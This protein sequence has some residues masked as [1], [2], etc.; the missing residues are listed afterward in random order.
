MNQKMNGIVNWQASDCRY[1]ARV[2]GLSADFVLGTD[3]LLDV[4]NVDSSRFD[5]TGSTGRV[6]VGLTCWATARDRKDKVTPTA[7][8]LYAIDLP[9]WGWTFTLSPDSLRA[10]GEFLVRH[11]AEADRLLDRYRSSSED[12]ALC[13]GQQFYWSQV[14]EGESD[15]ERNA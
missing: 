6:E 15:G 1:F 9:H 4:R 3:R 5:F 14:L 11:A 10:L 2:H 8:L 12:P 7:T 13:G